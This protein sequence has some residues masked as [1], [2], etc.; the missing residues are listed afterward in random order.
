M[1]AS[2]DRIAPTGAS[3]SN[4][5]PDQRDG[6]PQIAVVVATRRQQLGQARVVRLG[7]GAARGGL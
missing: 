4:R 1:T 5:L 3:V 2:E 7:V 6:G